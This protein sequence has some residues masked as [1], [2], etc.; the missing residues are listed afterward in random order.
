LHR[1][2][3]NRIEALQSTTGQNINLVLQRGVVR[4]Q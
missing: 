4:S 2:S 3:P 1:N